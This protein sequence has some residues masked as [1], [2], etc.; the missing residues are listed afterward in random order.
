ME[1]AKIKEEKAT[2]DIARSFVSD[3][4]DAKCIYI[5]ESGQLQI[6]YSNQIPNDQGNQPSWINS[7]IED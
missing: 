3:M 6:N 1:L 4:I 5:N 7:R 2:A